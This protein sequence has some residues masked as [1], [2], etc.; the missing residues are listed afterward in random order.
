MV[1]RLASTT[2]ARTQGRWR[3]VSSRRVF[4]AVAAAAAAVAALGS[5][6]VA[7]AKAPRRFAGVNFTFYPAVSSATA[8]Q[9]A[10]A[11]VRSVV[12]GLSWPAIEGAPGS[13]DWSASDQTVGDLAAAGIEP[14]PVLYGTP[15]WA[16]DGPIATDTNANRVPPT[17]TPRARASWAAFVQAAVARYGANGAYWQGPYQSQHPGAAPRPVHVWQPWSE[18]NLA[19]YYWPAPRVKSYAKLV[20]ISH[21]A[22]VGTDRSARIAVGGLVCEAEYGCAKY[23]RGFY[24]QPGVKGDFDLVALHPY[25]PTVGSVLQ[26]IR[27]A[28]RAMKRAHDAR[29]KVWVNEIGWGSA[30]NDHHLNKGP[31]GQARLLR[32]SFRRLARNRR[33]LRIWRIDWFDWR[34]PQTAQSGCSWCFS[35]G[36]LDAGGSPKPSF[37]AFKRVS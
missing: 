11:G 35:A 3:P 31:K 13:Y 36:L 7:A 19:T 4:A 12:F 30:P 25:A 24:R 17:R 23:L 14:D 33:R 8:E 21:D 27:G 5:P 32:S 20:K 15:R 9:M 34:D 1:G 37:K 22:I 18:A 6:P 26:G 2:L 28:R 16:L 29:T 10:R